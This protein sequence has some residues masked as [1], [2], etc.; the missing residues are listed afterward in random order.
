MS[1][2]LISIN[3]PHVQ[4]AIGTACLFNACSNADIERIALECRET[5]RSCLWKTMGREKGTVVLK[6]VD[7]ESHSLPSKSRDS[8]TTI[9]VWFLREK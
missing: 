2:P 4:I 7:D 3:V 6:Q 9:F 1:P 5:R 8:S